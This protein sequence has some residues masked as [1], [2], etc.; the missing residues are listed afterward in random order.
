MLIAIAGSS[1]LIGNALVDELRSH[2]AEVRR[3]VRRPTRGDDEVS[4]DPGRRSLDPAVLSGVDAV[5]NLAGA[6][7][8]DKR[9]TTEYKRIIRDSRVDSTATLAEAAAA[10]DTPPRVFVSAS[11]SSFYGDTGDRVTDEQAPSG[12][13]FLASVTRDWEAATAPAEKAGIRVVRM[14]TGLVCAPSGGLLAPLLPLF[15]LGVGG[16]LGSGR[17]YMPL[18]SLADQVAA[19]R[20]LISGDSSAENV[21]GPVNVCSPAPV[22]NREFAKLLGRILHRPALIPVPKLAIR[23]VRGEIANEIMDSQR[24][25]PR[26]LLAAGFAFSH[27]DAESILRWATGRQADPS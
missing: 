27:P 21:S 11:G 5:V 2:N 24:V 18:V 19:I 7:V 15:R 8:G 14:R 1:G 23:I 6:N 16:P 26:A 12:G 25:V 20:F 22:P 3:L 17:Q 9:L 13:G 4:W 10:A